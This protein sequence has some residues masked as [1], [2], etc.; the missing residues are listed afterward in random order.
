MR[1]G[2]LRFHMQQLKYVITN[3]RTC[4]S[5]F[6]VHALTHMLTQQGHTQQERDII[7]LHSDA[8]FVATAEHKQRGKEG[9][10][11]ERLK[12]R[13]KQQAGHLW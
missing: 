4:G 6:L 11:S 10:K 12:E 8:C 3:F 2:I 5:G 9:K 7:P 1:I 13:D